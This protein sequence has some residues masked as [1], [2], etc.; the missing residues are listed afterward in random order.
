MFSQKSIDDTPRFT[1][2][3]RTKIAALV[4]LGKLPEAKVAAAE[5]L[6]FDPAFTISAR[7]PSFREA[8]FRQRYYSGLKAAG[9]PE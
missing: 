8:D 9:L 5:F 1:S 3:H 7:L 4:H 6:T 2:A